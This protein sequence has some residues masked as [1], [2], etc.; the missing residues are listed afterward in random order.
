MES[1]HKNANNLFINKQ[2]IAAITIYDFLLNKNYKS[3]TMYSNKAACYLYIKDYKNSLENSLKSIELDLNNSIAWGRV[4]YSYKGL[5]MFSESLN[6]FKIAHKLDKNN[7]I[8]LNEVIFL[9]N[10]LN[11]KINVNNVFNKLLNNKILFN[12]LKD[13]K[14]DIINRDFDVC[15]NNNNI[16]GLMNEVINEL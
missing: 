15:L 11:D 3:T 10:R 4:G 2:Y 6:A 16:L 5:K 1:L 12:K 7:N 14:N 8:Y 13:F 9:H